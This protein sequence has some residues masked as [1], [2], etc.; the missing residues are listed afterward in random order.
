MAG[1]MRPT[2]LAQVGGR[3]R[4]ARR[5]R[6]LSVAALAERSGISR[7]M[8][9]QIEL[10]QAN[11]SVTLLDRVAAGLEITFAALIGIGGDAPPEGV[12]VWST[13]AGSWAIVLDAI[14]SPDVSVEM[15]RWN[16]VG[17]DTYTGLGGPP[18]TGKMLHVVDG[19]LEICAEGA[20]RQV[21]A[22]G[23]AHLAPGGTF[24]YR[25]ADG[26]AAV[27]FS[28]ALQSRGDPA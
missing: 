17:T 2:V 25:A 3:I 9:T 27:F 1:G 23:S 11:P 15:W 24:T 22:G 28:V 14:D 10:A 26:L 19:T 13:D 4:A 20:T 21:V 6:D 16:V 8:L 18:T 12:E 5:D 7:R